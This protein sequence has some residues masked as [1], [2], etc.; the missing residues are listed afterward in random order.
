[1]A[2]HLKTPATAIADSERTPVELGAGE[3]RMQLRYGVTEAESW[4]HFALGPQRERIWTRLREIDTR[5]IG[6]SVFDKGAP[7]PVRDWP[8]FASYVQAVLNAGAMPMMTFA[9]FHRPFDDPRAMRRFVNRCAD[10]VW[11]CIE[12]WGGEVVRDWY[13]CVWNE[14]NNAWTSG[15]FPFEQYRRIYEEVAQG[16]LRWLAPY[17]GPRKPRIGGPAVNGSLPFWMDWIWRF[18]NEIDNSLIGFVNWHRHGDWR[19]AGEWVA[20]DHEA[21]HRALVM[22]QT[23][24]YE[25]NALA[26]QQVLNGRGILNICGELNA[27]SHHESRV[28][29]PF[30]QTIFGAAFYASALLHL[31]RGGADA[32][33]FSTITDDAGRYGMLDPSGTP[34]P[35]FLAKRLCAQSLRYGDWLSFPAAVAGD[36]ALQV[37]VAR[38]EDG[39]QSA[40][41]AHLSDEVATYEASEWVQGLGDCRTLLKLDRGTGNRILTGAWEGRVTF[42]GYGVAVVTTEVI[43][44]DTA[45]ETGGMER[46]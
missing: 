43:E 28:S 11:G 44:T 1:V 9:R 26:I 3:V 33:L 35:V 22:F 30:N 21:D 13:W 16:V 31:I 27:H 19:Q 2:D 45:A 5:I 39:R 37:A 41:L 4:R 40:L 36:R 7:D 29:A 46:R 25:A 20:P 23:P 12:Q 24:E 15:N 38:G 6:I 18:V 10:V 8:T 42:E 34:T 32:E 17:L 14:P